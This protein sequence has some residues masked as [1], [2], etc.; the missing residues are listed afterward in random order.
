[1]LTKVSISLQLDSGSQAGVTIGMRL[2]PRQHSPEDHRPQFLSRPSELSLGIR[3]EQRNRAAWAVDSLSEH[4][5]PRVL[6]TRMLFCLTQQLD[7]AGGPAGPG[8]FKLQ[9]SALEAGNDTRP[10]VDEDALADA[11]GGM[12]VDAEDLGD[13]ILEVDGQGVPAALPEPVRDVPRRP[14]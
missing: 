1:M 3:N 8:I 12:D 5:V 2:L 10:V 11:R 6:G 7:T 13:A 4:L 14:R 9:S